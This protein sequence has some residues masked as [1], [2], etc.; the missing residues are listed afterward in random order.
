M[1]VESIG[2]HWVVSKYGHI[3]VCGRL[4]QISVSQLVGSIV[5]LLVGQ[6]VCGCIVLWFSDSQCIWEKGGCRVMPTHSGI[7]LHASGHSACFT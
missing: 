1:R 6:G 3:T 5:S 4:V 2:S 7:A